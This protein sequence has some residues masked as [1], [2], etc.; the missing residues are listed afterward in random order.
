MSGLR[1]AV[2]GLAGSGKSTLADYAEQFADDRGLRHAR[3]KLAQPLYQLQAEVYRV[4]GVELRAG[5]Q[6][7]LLMEHIAEAL[8]R[9]RPE[10]IV[11]S[12]FARLR[13][14]DADI[15]IND[16]LRDPDVDAPALRREGFRIVR[17]VADPR[18]RESRL[19]DRGDLTR[20]DRSTAELDR[21][22][23]DVCLLNNG[24]LAEYRE[25]GR[26][27]LARLL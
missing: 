7:Q 15:V 18:I 23:P 5:A 3:V 22:E 4:A 10:S 27:L 8:R 17:V 16:D 9:I 25:A 12:F 20:S 11:D 2:I 19:A 6:D 13:D 26:R 14:V 24:S 1:I 21:I